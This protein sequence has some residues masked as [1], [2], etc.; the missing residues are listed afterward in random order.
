MSDKF[1]YLT[2]ESD[3]NI[4]QNLVKMGEHLKALKLKVI[5][6]EAEYKQAVKEHD[7]YASSVLP[8]EMFNAGVSEIKL[9]SGG[10]MSY[11]RKFYCQPN[12]NADDRRAQVEWLRAN[13]GEHLIKESAKVDS[14]QMDKLK[15][16]GIPYAEVDDLNTN[17]LKAF[18]KDKIGAGTGVAQLQ[19][20]DIPES[21]HFQE[22]GFVSIE[23]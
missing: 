17:S 16:T 4:L 9:M 6:L 12:K 13:G 14:S 19:I 23:A 1:D 11:E 18:F 7:Y 8:M 10:V 5:E 20:Q 22:V 15:A 21:F 3:K 2:T